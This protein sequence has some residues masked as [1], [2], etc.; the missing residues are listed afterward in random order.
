MF[1]N[2]KMLHFCCFDVVSEKKDADGD[3]EAKPA[4]KPA[5]KPKKAPA[6]PLPEMM[7]EEIIPPLKAALE[8]EEDVSRVELSFQDSRVSTDYTAEK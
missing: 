2:S 1:L 3:T 8:A 6:K 5:V 4:V 7:Q